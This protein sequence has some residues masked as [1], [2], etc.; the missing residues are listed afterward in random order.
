MAATG[1]GSA[2]KPALISVRN[3]TEESSWAGKVCPK[4]S[5]PIEAGQQA[6]LCPKCYTPH[7]RT[8]WAENGNKCAVDGTPAN[9]L[10][11][12]AR[13]AAAAGAA[14]AASPAPAAP[15]FPAA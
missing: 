15:A 9:V 6:V 4:C 11:R 7:H 12:V 3:T 13:A 1:D 14:A 5:Q 8:C 10:E 2:P